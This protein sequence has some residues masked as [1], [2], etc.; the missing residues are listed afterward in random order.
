V[1]IPGEICKMKANG[2]ADSRIA[3]TGKREQAS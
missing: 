1:T 2:G 3:T